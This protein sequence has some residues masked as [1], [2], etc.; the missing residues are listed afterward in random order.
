MNK[1]TKVIILKEREHNYLV[2]CSSNFAQNNDQYFSSFSSVN[3][4]AEI[5]LI[6]AKI[7]CFHC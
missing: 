1:K 7:L 5:Q 2:V 4:L 6:D 3:W